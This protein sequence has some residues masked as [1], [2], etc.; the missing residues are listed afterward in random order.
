VFCAD[1]VN[2]LQC[3]PERM[4]LIHAP[5]LS[6]HQT[7]SYT[8][9]LTLHFV[10]G[11][12]CCDPCPC[13]HCMVDGFTLQSSIL[14]H[15]DQK[16]T[17]KSK[18]ELTIPKRA[19][20]TA[21][22]LHGRFRANNRRGEGGGKARNTRARERNFNITITQNQSSAVRETRC[23]I[24]ETAKRSVHLLRAVHVAVLMF[25]PSSKCFNN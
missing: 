14:N 21:G 2:V 16:R 19:S 20:A 13:L 6:R 12:N 15:Q 10:K 24:A 4:K 1:A 9:P 25:F 7:M 11:F 3:F 8:T 18:P 23:S 5:F 22:S 17:R